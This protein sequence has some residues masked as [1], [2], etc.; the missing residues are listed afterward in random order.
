MAIIY[1]ELLYCNNIILKIVPHYATYSQLL[2]SKWNFIFALI[3]GSIEKNAVSAA[4]HIFSVTNIW[5]CTKN[6]CLHF[7]FNSTAS[8]FVTFFCGLVNVITKKV[9]HIRTYY[10]KEL[11][12]MKTSKDGRYKSRWPLFKLLNSFL[13]DHVQQ[14]KSSLVSLTN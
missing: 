9:R 11:H 14:R 10:T 5:R 3:S 8:V 12:K 2:L 4:D 6:V 7:Y 13:C 1:V